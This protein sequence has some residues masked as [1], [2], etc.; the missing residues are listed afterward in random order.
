MKPPVQMA[1]P[2]VSSELAE[3]ETI[4]D[5]AISAGNPLIATEY[6][7]RLSRII[8]LKGIA[9][10]KLLYGMRSNWSLFRAA[11]IEEEY[12]DFI[13]AHMNSVSSKVAEKYANM[14]EEV[15]VKANISQELRDQLAGKQMKELLLLTAAVR[16][17]SIGE[18]ELEDVAL[19]DY[20]GIRQ[21]VR[22]A[23]GD[24]TSSKSAVYARLVQR[25]QAKWPKG[26]LVVFDGN[27]QAEPIGM[28]K[29]EPETA[30]GKK[31][32]ERL[33]NNMHLED[34]R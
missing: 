4:L 29:L 6:G 12:G 1:L 14:Y 20:E 19:L 24:V 8:K 7:N 28:L 15:F 11:G 9:L 16:E 27:G 23:R 21:I 10:A 18:E 5:R 3:V 32:L 13:N 25:D 34:I 17:G 26:T 2:Y 30:A 22:E 33:K 31:Y